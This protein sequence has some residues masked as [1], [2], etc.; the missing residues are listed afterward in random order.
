MPLH[1]M[2]LS[3]YL[4]AGVTPFEHLSSQLTIKEHLRAEYLWMRSC[5]IF[6]CSRKSTP[7][8]PFHA[9]CRAGDDA[10]SSS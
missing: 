3:H 5:T 9:S 4:L 1:R 10:K 8:S 6:T 2:R 7:S